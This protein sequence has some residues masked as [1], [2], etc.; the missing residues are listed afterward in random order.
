MPTRFAESL[1]SIHFSNAREGTV[2]IEQASL[3]ATRTQETFK[4]R[5]FKNRND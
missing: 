1:F 2:G 3:S 5:K 4:F